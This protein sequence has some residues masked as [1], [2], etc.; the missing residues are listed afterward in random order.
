MR[1]DFTLSIGYSR[2]RPDTQGDRW[3]ARVDTF[4]L[5][6]IGAIVTLIILVFLVPRILTAIG[7]GF[8]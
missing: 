3:E 4:G 1:I 5:L 8:G 6:V 7:L 2:R